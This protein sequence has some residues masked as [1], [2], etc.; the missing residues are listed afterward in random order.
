MIFLLKLAGRHARLVLAAGVLLGLFLPG[1]GDILGPVLQIMVVLVL[2]V[3]MV[4]VEL[5]QVLTHLKKPI[6]L[7]LLIFFLMILFPVAIH[8]IA[9]FL[10]LDPVLH[11]AVVLVACAPPLASA[12]NMAVLLNQDDAL[13]L[14]V[15]V[16]GT[17]IV[18]FT[19]PFLTSSFLELPLDIDPTSLFLRLAATVFI[20]ILL[21][22]LIRHFV[23]QER[24][25]KNLELYDGISAVI[26]LLFAIVIMN[27]IG[28]QENG[29]KDIF[30][31]TLIT[32]FASNWGVHLFFL[33][34]F[35]SLNIIMR[36]KPASPSKSQGA[37]ALMMGSRNAALFMAALP[38]E[39]LQSLLLFIALVQ[40]PI[41]LTPLAATPLYRGLDLWRQKTLPSGS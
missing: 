37:T 26:M 24:I 20:A 36:K 11:L 4:R 2:S 30:L 18:P 41:Y 35:I 10:E 15:M 9:V 23:G 32:A 6:R 38:A 14:N 12:P 8:W 5:V 17:L 1:L 7:S 19:V 16:I 28:L 39:T 40:F 22:A 27:G 31:V 33:G 13:V 34:L 21:A 29:D 3:A 25:Q